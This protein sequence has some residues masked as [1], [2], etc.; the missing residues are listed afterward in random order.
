MDILV[1]NQLP[2]PLWSEES[3]TNAGL[4]STHNAALEQQ[5]LMLFMENSSL[6]ALDAFAQ[7]LSVRPNST[8][9]RE[10][11]AL[12]YLKLRHYHKALAEFEQ[13]VNL[14]RNS[15][16]AYNNRG[17]C[18]YLLGDREKALEDLNRSIS[19]NPEYENAHA[20]RA[21]VYCALGRYAEAQSDCERLLL[22]NAEN[23]EALRI[24]REIPGDRQGRE[25]AEPAPGG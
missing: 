10:W 5:G 13:V 15:A 19:L 4:R 6:E 16:T 25:E 23:R 11:I 12:C 3:A 21:R 20:N 8:A 2:Y 1:P 9:I 24:Q 18:Y 7:A 22:L 17:L 14:E